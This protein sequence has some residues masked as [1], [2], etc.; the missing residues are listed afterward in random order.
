MPVAPARRLAHS[1]SGSLGVC[2][3]LR[4]QARCRA[5]QR[6]ARLLC[7]LAARQRGVKLAEAQKTADQRPIAHL[8]ASQMRRCNS[9]PSRQG[10][11]VGLSG[12]SSAASRRAEAKSSSA[13]GCGADAAPAA[14]DAR[15]ARGQPENKRRPTFQRC[16]AHGSILHFRVRTTATR[17]PT[18]SGH[19]Q[20]DERPSASAREEDALC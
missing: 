8:Q 3:G 11:Q 1:C 2:G 9:A 17:C 14:R 15:Y 6:L 13:P 16:A 19:P 4:P 5:F 10:S 20:K 18:R 12:S 7:S